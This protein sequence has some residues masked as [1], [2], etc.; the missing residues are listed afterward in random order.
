MEVST[1]HEVLRVAVAVVVIDVHADA[2]EARGVEEEIQFRVFQ[3]VDLSRRFEEGGRRV[4]D[5]LC[6]ELI[7]AVGPRQTVYGGG[8]HVRQEAAFFSNLLPDQSLTKALPGDGERFRTRDLH[9]FID[10]QG[11]G[12]ERVSAVCPHPRNAAPLLG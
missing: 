11:C 5:G 4:H 7:D 9:H 8:P 2:G 1:V 6:R 3:A 10:H 12:M